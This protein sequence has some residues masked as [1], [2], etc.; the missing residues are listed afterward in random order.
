MQVMVSIKPI[1]ETDDIL[2]APDLSDLFLK[3]NLLFDLKLG[4][5]VFREFQFLSRRSGFITRLK[6]MKS[7]TKYFIF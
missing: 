7:G 1:L 2:S 6:S 5:L 3:R 4:L